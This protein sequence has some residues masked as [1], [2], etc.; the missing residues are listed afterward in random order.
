MALIRLLSIDAPFDT[1]QVVAVDP[2]SGTVGQREQ[3]AWKDT[4]FYL[5][6]RSKLDNSVS[7]VVSV[8]ADD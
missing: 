2:I 3:L 7:R 8:V 4:H 5:A 6:R 1:I